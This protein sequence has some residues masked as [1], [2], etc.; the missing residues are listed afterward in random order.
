[1][2]Q[3]M[4]ATESSRWF[5]RATLLLMAVV[6][7]GCGGG[8]ESAEADARHAEELATLKKTNQEVTR[9]RTENVSLGR[10]QK[11]NE[12]LNRLRSTP[13]ELAKARALNDQLRARLGMSPAQPLEDPETNA[14]TRVTTVKPEAQA[15]ANRIAL[16]NPDQPLE[17]DDILIAP[18]QLGIF[19]PEYGTNWANVQRRAPIS[20][21]GLFKERGITFTNYSQLRELG[22][23]NYQIRRIPPPEP[24][25]AAPR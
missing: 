7:A 15:E 24:P 22:V 13:E 16:I 3:E 4:K 9:L 23:T 10:L 11:D 12:E 21:T 20:V 25:P 19:L 8:K 5:A 18:Q 17:G 6:L 2:N 14:T 1:M